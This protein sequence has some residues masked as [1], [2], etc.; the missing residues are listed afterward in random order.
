[1]FPSISYH[2]AQPSLLRQRSPYPDISY[3]L[4]VS[5]L[6]VRE[7][8]LSYDE[9]VAAYNAAKTQGERWLLAV[10]EL[11]KERAP[12]E[13]Y[14]SLLSTGTK[15][16]L[17]RGESWRG[18]VIAWAERDIARHQVE[19]RL[20]ESDPCDMV[21]PRYFDLLPW[22][23]IPIPL[24]S[25][26]FEPEGRERKIDLV[27]EK[28]KQGIDKVQSSDNFR[29]WLDTS[30]KFHQYS[31]GNQ[32]LIL[33]QTWGW[34]PQASQV[35][36]FNTWKDLGRFVKAGQEGIAILAPCLP[37]KGQMESAWKAGDK[38]W[39]L[40]GRYVYIRGHGL[41]EKYNTVEEAVQ[42]LRSQGAVKLEEAEASMT[43]NY[44]KVVYVF[45]VSQ[46]QGKELPTIEVPPLTGMANQDLFDCA[47]ALATSQGVTVSF[48][49]AP[50]QNPEIK[51]TYIG[52]LIWVKPD[53][54]EAQKLKTLIHEL[55]HYYTEHVFGIPRAEA[56][57][58][59][60]SAAY[61]VASHWGF[62][63]GTRSFP[64]VATWAKDKKLLEQNMGT[65]RKVVGQMVTQLEA[66]S[67][68]QVAV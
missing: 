55:C 65:I 11:D 17:R 4:P 18:R 57:V 14:R 16:P 12:D 38:E 63:T 52:K 19:S 53:E 1:M 51:G 36:G 34:K 42:W 62:D 67:Q 27:L 43:P 5:F 68:L 58:I 10:K 31:L 30:S 66:V 33:F 39:I 21:S 50:G 2:P 45:D 24:S 13:R 22:L 23:G 28:L 54:S 32:I 47:L 15:I 44:F 49:P 29:A 40:C 59:A 3:R 7:Q 8:S 35:A 46:T 37:P 9:Y 48:E 56:E 20:E 41:L 64:Y 6:K 26:A 25:F 61:A 60:E